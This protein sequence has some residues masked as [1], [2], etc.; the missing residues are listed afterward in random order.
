MKNH[1]EITNTFQPENIPKKRG[2]TCR[3][4]PTKKAVP[5][6]V[7]P[8]FPDFFG[9]MGRSKGFFI[10]LYK[11]AGRLTVQSKGNSVASSEFQK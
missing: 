6:G 3:F 5:W 9:E 8:D 2:L 1:G 10:L 11:D 7:K 4:A